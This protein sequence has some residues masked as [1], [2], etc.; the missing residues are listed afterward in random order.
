MKILLTGAN[1][2][3][4][5]EIRRHARQP[6]QIIYPLTRGQMDISSPDSVTKA[7]RD[8]KPN[9]VINAA[10]YTQVDQAETDA[11]SAYRVNR[12]GPGLLAVQCAKANIPLIHI[13]TDYVFDGMKGA[14]YTES[15]HI[16]PIGVYANS[17]AQGE[18]LVGNAPK[19]IIIRTSWVYGFYGN[20]FV[21][22]MSR[23]GRQKSN[24]GVVADQFGCPTAAG[25]LAQVILAIAH[26][27]A[28]EKFAQWG[29]YHF[30]GAGATTW[31]DF[32]QAVFKIARRF[33]YEPAPTITAITT[34]QYPTAARRPPYSVL[35][36]T[37]LIRTFDI[38]PAPWQSSLEPVV[39]EIMT[40]SSQALFS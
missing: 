8:N 36:C 18:T 37:R 29:C 2:Q 6:S 9:L 23:L 7:F 17:K 34:D 21:K 19:H 3:L 40:D 32:A 16:S 5:R 38:S 11:V 13:S 20:N 35:D 10:A 26:E 31:Y 30:C 25:D 12:D 4:G 39:K 1:G 24:I 27:I 14:P 22:T 15:E 28:D 33:G